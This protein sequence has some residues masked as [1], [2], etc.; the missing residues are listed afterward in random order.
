MSLRVRYN[1]ILFLL[2]LF[3]GGAYAQG[4]RVCEEAGLNPT[5]DSPFDKMPYVFGHISLKGLQ[6][7]AKPPRITI[8]LLDTQSSPSRWTVEKSGNYCFRLRTKSGGILVVEVEGMEV[9]R[10]TLSTF[11]TAQ[12]R[13]DFEISMA[14]LKQTNAPGVVSAKYYYPPNPKTA[15]LYRKTVEA[16]KKKDTDKAIEYLKEIIT[17]D[18]VDFIGWAKLGILYFEKNLLTEGEAALKKSVEIKAEYTPAWIHLGLLR[19][20]QQ[21]FEAASEI[22]KNVTKL[23]P[24]SPTAFRLLGESYLQIRKGALAVEALNKA[25]QLDP[26]G[27]ADC[28]LLLARLYDLAG[29]KPLA[30]REYKMFLS[31]LPD[32]PDR[33]KFEKYIKDNPE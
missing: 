26:F 3:V 30:T 12:Q 7:G 33:K 4:Y 24:T 11:G 1:L 31:K 19:A 21:Q 15:E 29:A 28:H 32:H 5:T 2:L 22:F 9:T 10:R 13:E 27:M 6:T 14:E 18:P 16:E 20:A 25:I 8:I 23:E 17:I